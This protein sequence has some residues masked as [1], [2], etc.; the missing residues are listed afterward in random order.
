MRLA[1]FLKEDSVLGD[2]EARDKGA[3]LDEV[4]E[5]ISSKVEGVG[6]DALL[7]AVLERERLGTTGIGHGVAIPHGKVEGLG[8]IRVFFAR[9]RHGVEF[10]SMDR[11]PVYLFF[12]ILVP[13]S[14]AAAHLKI[15]ASIARL[16]KN[17][18]LRARLMNA[19]NGREL[20]R[21]IINADRKFGPL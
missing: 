13:E 7:R 3:L 18:E 15:L 14:S 20:Y 19:A 8:R 1:D 5:I 21:I 4:M 6:S 10:E 17:K 2:L 12:F 11:M 16:L 9:S